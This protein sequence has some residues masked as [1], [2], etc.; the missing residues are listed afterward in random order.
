MT[1]SDSEPD[2]LANQVYRLDDLPQA[3]L[4]KYHKE[5]SR[6]TARICIPQAIANRTSYKVDMQENVAPILLDETIRWGDRRRLR[7]HQ[8]RQL[9]TSPVGK[10][11]VLVVLVSTTYGETPGLTATQLE[12]S[13]F[14]IGP[15]PQSNTMVTQYSNCS[16]GLLKMLPATGNNVV[17]GILNLQ[18]NSRVAGGD[19]EGAF[20]TT[21]YSATAAKLGV[22]AISQAATHIMYCLPPG[23]CAL[24]TCLDKNIH[25]FGLTGI[26]TYHGNES[27]HSFSFTGSVVKGN[28]QWAGFSFISGWVRDNQKAKRKRLR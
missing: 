2:G 28:N 17:N 1:T 6:G 22:S 27:W 13:I 4:K 12:G 14:G 24:C 7:Q 8:Q 10:H 26:C 20:Q 9:T 15:T 3:F 16:H 5:L 25:N 11:T 23:T 21:L 19:L 18:L